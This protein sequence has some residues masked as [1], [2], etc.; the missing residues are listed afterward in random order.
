MKAKDAEKALE[1]KVGLFVLMGMVCIGAMILKFGLIGQGFTNFYQLVVEFPNGSGLIKNS[2]V[3]LAGARIGYVVEKPQVTQLMSSVTVPIMIQSKVKIPRESEFRV[4]S[5][6]LL[7]DRFVEIVPTAKFD[8]SKFDPN[9]PQQVF[10]PGDKIAGSQAGGLEALQK[11]G[12]EVLDKLKDELDTLKETTVKINQDFL[13]D[14][15]KTNLT[16]TIA[17]LKT[18]SAGF[19][20]V[21]KDV[22]TLVQNAQGT[23]DTA[24]EAMDSAKKTMETANGAATDLRTTISSAR[25]TLDSV[26]VVIKKASQ[27]DGV[28]AN[29]LTNRE[30]SDNLK[31]LIANLRQRGILFYRDTAPRQPS[32]V[33]AR[34]R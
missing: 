19:V 18:T 9:D 30:L 25:Q 15:N 20:D 5:S 24:K 27:G 3:Q 14:Q 22:K 21:S 34:S 7:G 2:D 31:A 4:G 29:L 11:K 32:Q 13:S 33:P 6:G 1:F 23:M 26:N 17:N 28:I 12:E 10:A 16:D 8:S